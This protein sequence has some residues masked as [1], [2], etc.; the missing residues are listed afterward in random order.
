MDFINKLVIE[1]ML[2]RLIDGRISRESASDWALKLR[3]KADKNCLE[4][5]PREDEGILW[6]AI[7]FIEGIDLQDSPGVYLHN[8]D[9]ITNYISRVKVSVP[10][11]FGQFKSRASSLTLKRP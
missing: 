4:F 2:K 7:L 3:E 10:L 5:S 6:D 8:N 9:D 1:G 11:K